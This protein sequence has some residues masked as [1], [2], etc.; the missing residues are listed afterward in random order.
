MKYAPTKCF[1]TIDILPQEEQKTQVAIC[2]NMACHYTS[3]VIRTV[4]SGLPHCSIAPLDSNKKMVQIADFENIVWEPVL[5]GKH[6]AN[7]YLV[8]NH[9]H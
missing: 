8:R 3:N 2:L 4:V 5:A 9:C 7:T 6:A 1:W